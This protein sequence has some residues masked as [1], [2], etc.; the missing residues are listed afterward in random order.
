MDADIMQDPHVTIRASLEVQLASLLALCTPE[1]VGMH[2][3][4]IKSIQM[5]KKNQ[6][7]T[8]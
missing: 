7:V 1:Q 5:A 2:N 3:T 8:I 4:I 6:I